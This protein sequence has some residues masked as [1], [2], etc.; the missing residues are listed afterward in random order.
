MTEW[1]TSRLSRSSRYRVALFL[2]SG[3]GDEAV[4]MYITPV[5]LQA[6]M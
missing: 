4:Y 1:I 5:I 6:I 2:S 3:A